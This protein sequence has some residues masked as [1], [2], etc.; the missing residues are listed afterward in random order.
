MRERVRN[1]ASTAS[2]Q[3]TPWHRKV[4]HATPATPMLKAVTNST[5]SAILA[6]EEA[7]RNRKGVRESPREAKMPVAML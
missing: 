6:M 2:T 4:A 3:L 7:A 1:S 5:S